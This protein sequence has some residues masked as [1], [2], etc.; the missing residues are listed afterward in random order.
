MCRSPHHGDASP[1]LLRNDR[2]SR[3]LVFIVVVEERPLLRALT[4]M[5]NRPKKRPRPARI[6]TYFGLIGAGLPNS[7]NLGCKVNG[8]ILCVETGLAA[9]VRLNRPTGCHLSSQT[10]CITSA[11]RR[12]T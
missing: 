9:I 7:M 8:N 11:W 12:L 10:K 3:L 4:R 6:G 2:A 1:L 5:P